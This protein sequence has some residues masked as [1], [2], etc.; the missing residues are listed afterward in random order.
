[1]RV[2]V[3]IVDQVE[4]LGKWGYNSV[5]IMYLCEKRNHLRSRCVQWVM[6]FHWKLYS[7]P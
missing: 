2:K 1:M 5:N 6:V 7:K 4:M 3:F